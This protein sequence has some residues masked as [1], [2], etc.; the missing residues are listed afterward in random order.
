VGAYRGPDVGWAIGLWIIAGLSLVVTLLFGVLAAYGFWISH[1]MDE[2]GVTTPAVVTQVDGSD[3]T[4]DFTTDDGESVTAEIYWMPADVPA[5]G[6]EVMITYDPDDVTYA[7][8][9]GS[10]ED[11]F[12]AIVF[13]VAAGVGLLVMSG[14]GIGAILVHSARSRN[15]KAAYI[16]PA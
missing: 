10:N 2:D 13:A 16:L 9:D 11:R 7:V 5:T 15:A 3:V 4:I 8:P 14:A 1:H 12:L 6:E